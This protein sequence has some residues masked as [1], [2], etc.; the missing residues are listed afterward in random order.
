MNSVSLYP[1]ICS[2]FAAD[3]RKM[4]KFRKYLKIILPALFIAYLGCLVAFTHVHIV[5]GVTIVH[6]HPYQTN[7]EGLPNH[8]HGYAEFQLL[9]Q[10]SVLQVLGSSLT[11][12]ILTVFYSYSHKLSIIPVYPDYLIPFRGKRTLRA[13]P[14]F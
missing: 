5:N 6:S 4:D 12:A 14:A 7:D 2:I 1:Q 9:H 3:I 13:P 8:V 11:V 10:L